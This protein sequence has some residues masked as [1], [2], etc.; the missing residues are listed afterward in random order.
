MVQMLGR[1]LA[2]DDWTYNDIC[3]YPF[4]VMKELWRYG[5]LRK[6]GLVESAVTKVTN[7][8]SSEVHW[9]LQEGQRKMSLSKEVKMVPARNIKEPKP[10]N[11]NAPDGK[12]FRWCGG[13]FKDS[14]G[15]LY[16]TFSWKVNRT[17]G[18]CTDR[19]T[20]ARTPLRELGCT[21]EYIHPSI[22]WRIK[23]YENA[24]PGQQYRP[25][26]LANFTRKRDKDGAW[27][28]E[29]SNGVW[30]PEW[31]V[32]PKPE[33]DNNSQHDWDH[34]EWTLTEHIGDPEL[35]EWLKEIYDA[36]IKAGG[37]ALLG[38]E[39]RQREKTGVPPTN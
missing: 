5:S 11:H 13:P 4:T 38:I 22:H 14:Y 6:H 32:K 27:G 36:K 35:R 39:I 19:S 17:P 33:T 9:L 23:T 10:E 34:A 18:E 28:Y 7:G 21:N 15:F 29:K 31:V 12:P 30:I 25:P 24:D 3:D 26:A 2:F 20:E 16:R 37:A 1:Y 8:I